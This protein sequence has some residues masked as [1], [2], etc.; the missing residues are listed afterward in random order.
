MS[1]ILIIGDSH[2]DGTSY[3]IK[4]E[5]KL[6]ALGHKVTRAGVGA[7]SAVQWV[8]GTACRPKKDKC[9]E[10]ADLPKGTDLLLISL[11]TNDAANAGAAK[12]D[13][14]TASAKIAKQMADL[15]AKFGAKRTV[16]VGPPWQRGGKYYTQAN[17][18][19]LYDAAPQSGLEVFDS[20]PSTKEG[21]LGGSGDGVH[22]G[23]KTAELW[24]QATV[25][26]LA[27]PQQP[28]QPQDAPPATETTETPEQQP[29]EAGIGWLLVAALVAYLLF[30]RKS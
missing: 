29:Q 20:R 8:K 11:G 12:K 1:T 5:A 30:R 28:P 17:M 3:G 19:A 18:D 21:V 15:A 26:Y 4:L 7:T 2:V 6:K 10:V 23:S 16:W 13:P 9:V 27:Q 14:A 25:D 22:P 24:A